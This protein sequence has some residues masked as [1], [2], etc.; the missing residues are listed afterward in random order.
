MKKSRSA[1]LEAVHETARDLHEA[2]LM[3]QKTLREYDRLCAPPIEPFQP[4][5]IRQIR[6]TQNVSQAVFA[7]ALNTSFPLSRNG[8]LARRS[9]RGLR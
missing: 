1:I 3:S 2:G 9:Q 4:A 6:E 5:Q 7:L 8:R